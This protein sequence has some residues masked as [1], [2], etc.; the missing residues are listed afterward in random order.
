MSVDKFLNKRRITKRKTLVNHKNL[1]KFIY[2]YSIC[3]IRI[4]NFSN[5]IF[6]LT[7]LNSYFKEFC[8]Q[9]FSNEN[10]RRWL[11]GAALVF[12]SAFF[13]SS[14]STVWAAVIT[15]DSMGIKYLETHPADARW[16]KLES[17]DY[18]YVWAEKS[19][20][21]LTDPISVDVI[22]FLNNPSGKYDSNASNDQK[23]WH[24]NYV[25]DGKPANDEEVFLGAGT[26]DS[27]YFHADKQGDNRTFDGKIVFDTAVAAIA[28]RHELNSTA[29]I[30]AL[31]TTLYPA[32][33]TKNYELGGNSSGSDS[34]FEISADLKTLYFSTFVPHDLDTL[35][36]ITQ[37]S[38]VPLPAALPLYGAGLAALGFLAWRR[39][40][41]AVSA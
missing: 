5:L 30:F 6:S 26:Y 28:F 41:Q 2:I 18:A 24:Y 25:G 3:F 40:R 16:E 14:A 36:I 34:Y 15:G 4:T 23:S 20:V 37:V 29:L 35:R 9:I 32:G 11:F 13:V 21:T 38:A 12:G 39:K 22:P 1:W 7:L 27:Y 17:N 31:D 10:S 19:G 8:M 33:S